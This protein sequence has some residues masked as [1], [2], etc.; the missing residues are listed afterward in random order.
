MVSAMRSTTPS[1]LLITLLLT[2]ILIVY[3]G[4]SQAQ[5]KPEWLERPPDWRAW[6]SGRGGG[7]EIAV[8]PVEK[9]I[10]LLASTSDVDPESQHDVAYFE[11]MLFGS[12][13]SSMATYYAENSRNQTSIEGKVV[14]WLDLTDTL[15]FYDEDAWYGNQGEYGVGLGVEEAVYL[16]DDEVDFSEYDQNGDSI[17]DNIMVV[18]VGEA[19]S[20]NGD[21]DG[22]GSPFDVG[23]I[24]PLQWG[25]QSAYRT[26]D[27]VWISNFFVC[28]EMCGMGT[29]AH[30]FGHNL[31]VPD[32]Y[33]TDMSSQGVGCW[34][35]MS[36]GNYLTYNNQINP[37]HFDAWSK[38]K[39]G[40]VEPVELDLTQVARY[41]LTPVESG[42][43]I[44]KFTIVDREGDSD[45]AIY[46]EYRDSSSALF[47]RGL[48][49]DGL[50]IWHVDESIE[51]NEDE[52]HPL[53]RL[54]QADGN[55]DLQLSRNN[56][57]RFD[58]WTSGMVLSNQSSPNLL[59]YDGS[60]PGIRIA[61]ESMSDGEIV[62]D[63]ANGDEVV[64]AWFHSVEWE[65]ED[66]NNDG[67]LNGVEFTYDVDSEGEFP[68]DVTVGIE[69]TSTQSGETMLTL[70][71]E[72]QVT[73]Q[74]YDDF[75]QSAG[76]TGAANGIYDI[77][78]L[79]R[80][81]GRIVDRWEPEH[82][83]WLEYPDSANQYDEWFEPLSV[84][85]TD[86]DDD[87]GNDTITVEFSVN[88]DATMNPT[89]I[90]QLQA[91]NVAE[92]E[93]DHTLFHPSLNQPNTGTLETLDLDM[94][95]TTLLPGSMTFYVVLWEC[96]ETCDDLRLEEI[97]V[98]PSIDMAW[99]TVIL[100]TSTVTS[101]DLD[102]DPASDGLQV[103]IELDHSFRDPVDATIELRRTHGDGAAACEWTRNLSAMTHAGDGGRGPLSCT[104]WEDTS[105]TDT[106]T[107]HIVVETDSGDL[108][109]ERLLM[110]PPPST[111]FCGDGSSIP[112]SWLIDGEQDC[113]DGSDEEWS[114]LAWTVDGAIVQTT[115]R[116]AGALPSDGD[117]DGSIDAVTISYEVITTA[118]SLEV[119]VVVN[120]TV[121]GNVVKTLFIDERVS[122]SD[123]ATFSH[124]YS[125]TEVGA[126]GINISVM[127]SNGS[128]LLDSIE[129]GPI[130]L[131]R[132]TPTVSVDLL[133]TGAGISGDAC[134][135]EAF[136]TD[137]SQDFDGDSSILAWSGGPQDIALSGEVVSC[138][139]W[140]AG[141]YDVIVTYTSGSGASDSTNLT[142]ELGES[143]VPASQ[144]AGDSKS[145]ASTR[146]SEAESAGF[147]DVDPMIV[148]GAGGVVLLLV[149]VLLVVR[150]RG[151]P[152]PQP[153][154]HVPGM[155]PQMQM[156]QY[157]APPPMSPQPQ[158]PPPPSGH[159]QG[160]GQYGGP[161][162]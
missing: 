154:I 13:T 90:V 30:E 60:D 73:G 135:I 153:P 40:W 28:T 10:V 159:Q 45:E 110:A 101:V 97:F 149:V 29:F 93:T 84:F 96:Q 70:S 23:A 34:S 112:G 161:P 124:L 63:L 137:P 67:F 108:V 72:H 43:E 9:V 98:I 119:L 105:W 156:G 66:T 132:W 42:G 111:F 21:A 26:A 48:P 82:A 160:Y 100:E 35:I 57:D 102:G 88:T 125:A 152:P 151:G 89:I 46:V 16:A 39:L 158:V 138:R 115:L 27:N 51:T 122:E 162:R 141:T 56:G 109:F 127:S 87:G 128:I 19:D 126:H 78:V 36:S 71:E 5:E 139:T 106:L 143:S 11:E 148:M 2:S 77:V 123:S 140:P 147:T 81:D 130:S 157:G 14:G 62:L 99:S 83:I 150:S 44:L 22:D 61:I 76:F 129:L 144:P 7:D 92:P 24:W 114:V 47:D 103:T 94:R 120:I 52:N 6:T 118:I 136:I 18:F 104:V 95:T 133:H 54:V 12:G 55:R 1:I 15:G 91:F 32:L 142:L 25:L 20:A 41:T 37:A 69:F 38:V 49:G 107:V 58:V 8:D 80:L 59:T 31:G 64:D 116:S 3:S 53:V 50:L 33:D 86:D 121:D 65:W 113:L 68:V 79:L 85:I 134:R 4:S 145:N 146:A 155:P 75:S 74:E 117:G 131:S 17:V